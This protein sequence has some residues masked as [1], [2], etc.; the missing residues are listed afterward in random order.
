MV[1]LP[2]KFHG[3]IIKFTGFMGKNLSIGSTQF[4]KLRNMKFYNFCSTKAIEL[5]F[6][7]FTCSYLLKFY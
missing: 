4:A 2:K 5:T 1:S 3:K 6:E 7:F